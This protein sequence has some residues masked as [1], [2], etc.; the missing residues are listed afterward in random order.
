MITIKKNLH[1]ICFVLGMVILISGLV[2]H[3][4]R[5]NL[6]VEI[7][8]SSPVVSSPEIT[9]EVDYPFPSL[10]RASSDDSIT[11]FS[12]DS[13]TDIDFYL[14]PLGEVSAVDGGN[15]VE[16]GSDDFSI[17]GYISDGIDSEVGH[18]PDFDLPVVEDDYLPVMFSDLELLAGYIKY[19]TNLEVNYLHFLDGV[20][21][22]LKDV[23]FLPE[24]LSSDN[25]RI[26]N[27]SSSD[28]T[29]AFTI[30]ENIAGES[31]ILYSI[32]SQDGLHNR[33]DQVIQINSMQYSSYKY[34]STGELVLLCR[35]SFNFL[36]GVVTV[37]N[38]VPLM[39]SYILFDSPVSITEDGTDFIFAGSERYLLS[40]AGGILQVLDSGDGSLILY[41]IFN[42]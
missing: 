32:K 33:V 42:N 17:D 6:P 20:Q 24:S 21:L 27:L 35:D 26:T 7:F 16:N 28:P 38:E 10:G 41:G 30:I 23:M 22:F 34:L 19:G 12:R 36:L 1:L 25:L 4:F 3:A 9:V 8:D 40:V 5:S 15:L 31:L 13:F 11:E 39:T 29:Q 18:I 2:W 37:F 14:P